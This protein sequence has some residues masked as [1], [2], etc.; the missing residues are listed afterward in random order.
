MRIAFITYEYPSEIGLGGIGTYTKQVATALIKKGL[1][2]SVFCGS[3]TQQ[4][5]YY[6]NGVKVHS[7]KCTN[8]ETFKFNVVAPFLAEHNKTPFDLMES[9]EIHGNAA[10]VKKHLPSLPLVVRLHA[11]NYLVEKLKKTYTPF[12]AKI[13]FFMGALRRGRWDLGYWRKYDYKSDPDY[14]FVIRADAIIAP[15]NAMKEWAVSNWN[16]NKVSIEVIPNVFYP[17]KAFL[18]IERPTYHKRIVYFGRLNVLKGLVG[19]TKAMRVFLSKNPDWTWKVIGN[20]GPSHIFNLSM[21]Q[22]MKKHLKE[23][24]NQV[25]FIDGVTYE[26]L[27]YELATVDIALLPSLFESF[28]YTCKEALAAGLPVIGSNVGGMAD[29]ITSSKQG[30]LVNPKSDKQILQALTVFTSSTRLQ[31]SQISSRQ[32]V[33]S[34]DQNNLTDIYIDYYKYFIGWKYIHTK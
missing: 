29:M 18:N 12:V 32:S 5:F 6:D 2:I 28:S 17:D 20:D 26:Q 25:E 4:K 9:P 1:D 22:W 19:A 27:P 10:E 14:N 15:S 3:F 33:F 31:T 16:I 23:V 13:R 34:E 30:C 8:P 11:P 21:R 24:T 7:I